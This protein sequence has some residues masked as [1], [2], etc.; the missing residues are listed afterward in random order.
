MACSW[1]CRSWS[2]RRPFGLSLPADPG[3]AARWEGGAWGFAA[4]AGWL[5]DD[6]FGGSASVGWSTGATEVAAGFGV[7]AGVPTLAVRAAAEPRPGTELLA[8]AELRDAAVGAALQGASS[9][10]ALGVRQRV[11][12]SEFYA[13]GTLPIGESAVWS[14]RVGFREAPITPL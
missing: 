13:D 5:G 10:V 9:R 4:H 7:R 3:L 6:R 11:A 2:W 1:T 14:G 8:S 12:A